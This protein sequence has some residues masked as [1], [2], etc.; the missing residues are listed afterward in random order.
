M[1]PLPKIPVFALGSHTLYANDILPTT[2][3]VRAFNKI[4]SFGADLGDVA[5]ELVAILIL[6][7]V[8]F[9]IGAWLFARRHQ[10]V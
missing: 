5:F 4:L 9:A 10:R 8:Y 2:L 6:T 7:A 1:F 3:C